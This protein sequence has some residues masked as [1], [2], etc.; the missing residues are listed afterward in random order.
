MLLACLN[1][2]WTL[3]I[4]RFEWVVSLGIGHGTYYSIF[5][6]VFSSMSRLQKLTR[7]RSGSLISRTYRE[8]SARVSCRHDMHA[9]LLQCFTTGHTMTVTAREFRN[10]HTH[11]YSA[12]RSTATQ[13]EEK[14]TAAKQRT[15]FKFRTCSRYM[16]RIIALCTIRITVRHTVTVSAFVTCLSMEDLNK[17]SGVG[18]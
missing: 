3:H 6:A 15:T 14:R 11:W 1:V 16:L 13:A 9:P 18:Q 5:S 8:K 2:K 4:R 10:L 17:F 7:G 12:N